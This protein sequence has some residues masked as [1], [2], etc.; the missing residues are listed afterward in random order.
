M[1]WDIV[2]NIFCNYQLIMWNW[3]PSVAV[4]WSARVTCLCEKAARAA[5][6]C[7][8]EP[9]AYL[10]RKILDGCP[11]PRSNFL[12]YR[13]QGKV[14]FSKGSVSHSV[15]N[16][17]HGYSV[18]AYPCYGT[19]GMYPTGMLSCFNAVFRIIWPNI[20]LALPL[21]GCPTW[22]IL[23]PLSPMSNLLSY[24]VSY[25]YRPQWSCEGYDFTGVCLSTVGGGGYPSMPCRWYPSMPYSRSR[26]GGCAI[27][28]CIAGGIPA[29]LPTG[30]QG[31]A[32]SGGRSAPGGAWSGGSAPRWGV[33]GRGGGLVSQHALRQT[34]SPWERRPLLWIVRIPLECI[35][36]EFETPYVRYCKTLS[37]SG[38][39][40]FGNGQGKES[41]YYYSQTTFG[42]R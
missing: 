30:L 35:L 33:P 1:C 42:T 10:P 21:S 28:A 29:C 4:K 20:R 31:G 11:P 17:P 41:L 37:R 7:C 38:S 25:Y 9:V 13:P 18:T 22:E 15:H 5:D 27:P 32:W 26:G 39:R 14:M 6:R 16:R 24:P 12:N 19:V 3:T 36:V 2:R 40:N 8:A 23:D 34:P